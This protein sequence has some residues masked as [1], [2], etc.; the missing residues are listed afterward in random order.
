MTSPTQFEWNLHLLR[1]VIDDGEGGFHVGDMF[2][3][4]IGFWSDARLIG[5]VDRTKAVVC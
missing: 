3:W 1:M 5:A 2:N 4:G